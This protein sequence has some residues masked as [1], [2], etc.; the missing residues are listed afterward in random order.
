MCPGCGGLQV[1]KQIYDHLGRDV[2][3]VNAAGC[4]TLLAPYPTTPFQSSWIYT[5]MASAPA[6]AQGLVDAIEVL[7]SKGRISGRRRVHVVVLTGDGA[8]NGIGLSATSGALDRRLDFY[9]VCYDNEGYGNTGHQSS[10]STPEG[11]RTATDALGLGCEQSKKDLFSI[12]AAHEP[13][14][15]ATIIGAEPQD[16]ARKMERARDCQGP[17]MFIALAPC[18]T[19]WGFDPSDAGKIGQLAVSTGVWA[20]KERVDGKTVH[21]K[22]PRPR[23]L[24]E[25]YLRTQRR[26]EHLF[27]PVRRDDVIQRIQARIT[28]EWEDWFRGH[29]ARAHS[30]LA[31]E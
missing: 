28:D 16:L 30:R 12:W 8:A 2:V 5:S 15:L 26:F 20:L 27:S 6:G 23:R 24:V 9:Y 11:A 10:P 25:D 17:K 18:P 29:R 22:I 19:G 1:V 3:F 21:T 31:H 7:R 4:L 13:A 14:Y